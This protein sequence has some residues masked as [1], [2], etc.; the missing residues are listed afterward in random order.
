MSFVA[1]QQNNCKLVLMS[2]DSLFLGF[3]SDCDNFFIHKGFFL[4]LHP[5]RLSSQDW[6]SFAML[7]Y[8]QDYRV[9]VETL[10]LHLSCF[11]I[12]TLTLLLSFYPW[13]TFSTRS[14]EWIRFPAWEAISAEIALG[15]APSD[16]WGW[17]PSL[18]AVMLHATSRTGSQSSA[19]RLIEICVTFKHDVP[20]FMSEVILR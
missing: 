2:L 20:S 13:R 17:K 4:F 18:K 6:N 19:E 11:L 1:W 14:S 9:M 15:A 8:S 3:G 7:R 5:Q 16:S 10:L 12:C